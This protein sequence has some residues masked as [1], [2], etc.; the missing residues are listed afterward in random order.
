MISIDFN[1]AL[2]FE[3]CWGSA[4]LF[5]YEPPDSNMAHGL[6]V[7][8]LLKIKARRRKSIVLGETYERGELLSPSFQRD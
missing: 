7:S 3:G 1:L 6:E 8:T 2:L 4:E 5:S